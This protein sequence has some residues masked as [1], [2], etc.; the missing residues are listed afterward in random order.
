VVCRVPFEDWI[1]SVIHLAQVQSHPPNRDKAL[2]SI[3]AAAQPLR[4]L[5]RLF[6]G[7]AK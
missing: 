3:S 2:S 1:K 5:G 4:L 7:L 6:L